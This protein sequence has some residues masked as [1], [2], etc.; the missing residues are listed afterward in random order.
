M[1][2]S[3]ST[4]SPVMTAEMTAPSPSS[5]GTA[6]PIYRVQRRDAIATIAAVASSTIR[7]VYVG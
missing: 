4:T 1:A 7:P 2:M 5:V 3:W 6:S